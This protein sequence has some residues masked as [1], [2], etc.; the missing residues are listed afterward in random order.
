MSILA[1]REKELGELTAREG[2]LEKAV[3][4]VNAPVIELEQV[5]AAKAT[6]HAAYL[7]AKNEL[8]QL[9][10]ERI[11]AEQR[12]ADAGGDAAK[13]AQ[14]ADDMAWLETQL[15]SGRLRELNM[16]QFDANRVW[17]ALKQ[18]G[19]QLETAYATVA[20]IQTRIKELGGE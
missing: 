16:D 20:R 4:H 15:A 14:M 17:F 5:R 11:D 1:E 2:K 13:L 19:E 9:T 18:L 3:A 6:A 7:R 12:I 8:E 10:A